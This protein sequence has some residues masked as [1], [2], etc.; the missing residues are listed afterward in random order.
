[1]PIF[2]LQGAAEM[3]KIRASPGNLKFIGLHPQSPDLAAPI[4]LFGPCAVCL[5]LLPGAFQGMLSVP[6]QHQNEEDIT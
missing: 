6:G 4:S 3:T 2:L 1:M 5:I